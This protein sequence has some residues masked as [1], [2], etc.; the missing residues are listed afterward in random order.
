MSFT[1]LIA[2]KNVGITNGII[3]EISD[4][5]INS[6]K[7]IDAKNEI[8]SPGFIDLHSHPQDNQIFELQAFDGVTT[9]LELEVGTADIKSFYKKWEGQ[10]RINFGASIGHIPVRMNVMDDPGD[11]VP[12]GDAGSREASNDEIIKMKHLI[13]N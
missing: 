13:M 8:I 12:A 10:S 1:E 4:G 9:T 2:F 7:I 5:P 6:E 3:T 11:F